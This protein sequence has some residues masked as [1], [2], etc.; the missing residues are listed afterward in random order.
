MHDRTS[1]VQIYY[2]PR[3]WLGRKPKT[4]DSVPFGGKSYAI[5]TRQ[6]ILPGTQADLRSALRGEGASCTAMVAHGNVKQ[7]VCNIRRNA[8]MMPQCASDTSVG[9][10]GNGLQQCVWWLIEELDAFVSTSVPFADVIESHMSSVGC[11]QIW[12]RLVAYERQ[13][14]HLLA[15]CNEIDLLS[16]IKR[17]WTNHCSS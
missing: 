17:Q 12:M 4:Y 10:E 15:A 14:Q 2:K 5:V 8:I 7:D 1:S 3:S 6:R 16:R 13:T 11:P 9:L